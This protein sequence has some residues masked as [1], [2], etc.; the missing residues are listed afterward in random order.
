M[1]RLNNRFES[2][3]KINFNQMKMTSSI[4]LIQLADVLD[5]AECDY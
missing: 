3:M 1:N 2:D 5:M 4:K